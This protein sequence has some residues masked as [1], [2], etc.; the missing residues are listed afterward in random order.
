MPAFISFLMQA[1]TNFCRVRLAV[2]PIGFG[3]ESWGETN[4]H[5]PLSS[6]LF[7]FSQRAFQT[8]ILDVLHVLSLLTHG[9]FA[10]G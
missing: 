10:S 5:M 7:Q 4:G 2:M 6:A 8:P 9:Q 3:V 1:S